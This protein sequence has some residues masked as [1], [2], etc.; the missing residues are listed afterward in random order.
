MTRDDKMHMI[1]RVIFEMKTGFYNFGWE[2]SREKKQKHSLLD[3]S[4]KEGLEII[5]LNLKKTVNYFKPFYRTFQFSRFSFC[6]FL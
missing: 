3:L 2:N 1:G 5:K 4:Q 6:I